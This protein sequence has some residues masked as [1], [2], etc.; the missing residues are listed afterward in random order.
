MG[1]CIDY[2]HMFN[3]EELFYGE[4]DTDTIVWNLLLLIFGGGNIY[5]PCIPVVNFLI[6][7]INE[8]ATRLQSPTNPELLMNGNVG[9]I[10]RPINPKTLLDISFPPN[11]LRDEYRS[12]YNYD[13][14]CYAYA[15][16]AFEAYH[17]GRA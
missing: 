4:N 8:R 16:N 12:F 5:K 15:S 10:K 9:P 17:F 13:K 6:N 1:H 11:I 7:G 14:L 3:T 2:T